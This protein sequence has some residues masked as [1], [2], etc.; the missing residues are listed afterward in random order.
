MTGRLAKV[1]VWLG[2]IAR[3]ASEARSVRSEASAKRLAMVRSYLDRADEIHESLI[4]VGLRIAEELSDASL[5]YD[6][7]F[8]DQQDKFK[9]D[10]STGEERK[11]KFNLANR[12]V[13]RKMRELQDEYDYV[14]RATAYVKSVVSTLNMSRLEA[15]TLYK[16][17]VSYSPDEYNLIQD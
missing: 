6:S 11:A 2:D 13:W 9:S 10:Y 1:E 17:Q 4:L 16:A 14:L 8:I 7:A 5:S 12:A 15:L 3:L